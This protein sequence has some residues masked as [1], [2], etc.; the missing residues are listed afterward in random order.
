M[1][2]GLEGEQEPWRPQ[3]QPRDGQRLAG[4]VPHVVPRGPEHG[5]PHDG[6]Q[7][8]HGLPAADV[9]AGDGHLHDRPADDGLR[10]RVRAQTASLNVTPDMP[11]RRT[12]PRLID[13]ARALSSEPVAA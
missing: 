13:G 7:V 2:V 5:V 4:V 8:C 6:D 3:E 11:A 10:L 1:P 12:D 9:G